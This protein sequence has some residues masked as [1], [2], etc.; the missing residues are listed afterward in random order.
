M[1]IKITMIIPEDSLNI[2]SESYQTINWSFLS[3]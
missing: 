2:Y 3:H 1:I